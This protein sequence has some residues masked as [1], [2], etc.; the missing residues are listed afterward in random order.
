MVNLAILASGSG[1]NAENLIR[2]FDKNENVKISFIISNKQDALV[3]ERAAKWH[4]PS[5]TFPKLAFENGEVR[6]FLQKS[7]IDMIILAGFLLRLPTTITRSY[8]HRI[9]NIHPALLP[10][11]GG[12]GMYG[13]HVH[14]AVI[15]AKETVSGISIHYVNGSY[16]K[17]KL[18]FQS[19]C[20]VTPDDT[21]E[22][23]AEKVHELEYRYY[24]EIINEEIKLQFL[25]SK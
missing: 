22:T 18:I 11:Y 4:I 16:D 13:R 10:K 7:G 23:L 25:D 6:A 20:A 3:H 17:G 24:P 5:Y 19:R 21:P 12:K 14:E 1:T 9:I 15:N 2:Y 8:P